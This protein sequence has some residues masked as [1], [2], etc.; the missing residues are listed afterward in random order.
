MTSFPMS[1][2]EL[3]LDT[4]KT[5]KIVLQKVLRIGQFY[6]KFSLYCAMTIIF[7]FSLMDYVFTNVNGD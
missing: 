4:K 7:G 5:S 1:Y 6:A 2:H 3:N